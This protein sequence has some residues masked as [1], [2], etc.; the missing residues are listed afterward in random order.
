MVSI[1]VIIPSYNRAPLLAR[2][3][4]SV[5]QQ[6]RPAAE[7]IIIDDGSTDDTRMMISRHF[8]GVRYYHQDNRG[9]SA[10]RN[11]GIHQATGQW[12]AFLDSD[13][14]WLPEKLARQAAVIE[15][16]A[17]CQL[18]HSDEIWIRHSRRVNPM[19]KHRK[20]G[21]NIFSHCLPRCVISPSAV[22]I[23]ATLLKEAGLF[24][25]S[26]PACE[27][28]DLWL[29]ICHRYAVHYLDE[30]LIIKY[31]GHEDQLS[32]RH[33]GMDRFRIRALE[34]LLLLPSLSRAQRQAA[35]A[36]LAK[37]T[38]I[39]LQGAEKRNKSSEIDRCRTL[40]EDCHH[41]LAILQLR[42]TA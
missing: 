39:Y 14:T 31:G 34:K 18:V 29:R 21:G 28:Y 40:L 7:V 20:S 35:L 37:K 13:D 12:L 3:L 41:Q 9:V 19:K 38:Q 6:T 16:H 22:A 17:D 27:D 36:M 30:P 23:R 1:S 8:P 4:R 24:D 11:H 2:A 32:R 42:D 10:A 5:Y 26:L 15:S 33:W 25:E